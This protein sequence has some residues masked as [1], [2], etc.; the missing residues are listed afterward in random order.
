MEYLCLLRK[1]YRK[2]R[3]NEIHIGEIFDLTMGV[4]KPI[5]IL[6]ITQDQLAIIEQFANT[7]RD[8]G[9]NIVYK[10]NDCEFR[11]FPHFAEG[12]HSKQI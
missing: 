8:A 4:K 5:Q 2:E 6:I 3:A 10:I 1:I 9:L 12:I 11:V 7:R